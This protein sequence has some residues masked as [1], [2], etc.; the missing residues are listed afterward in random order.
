MRR[1]FANTCKHVN[2]NASERVGISK[3]IVCLELV[4]S[5]SRLKF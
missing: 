3:Y 4:F 2:V 1:A 5:L